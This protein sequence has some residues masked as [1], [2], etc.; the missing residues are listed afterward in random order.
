M[1]MDIL[2]AVSAGA[3]IAG[4]VLAVRWLSGGR[5][6]K[7]TIPAAIGA[8]IIAFSIWS[9]YSWFPR[10][11]AALPAEAP[12][13]LA[14][15]DPSPLR[16]WTY[17]F[18]LTT[19]FVAL[20]RTAMVTSAENPAIRRADAVVVQRW[21][22]TKRVPMG[23][24]CA[25]GRQVALTEGAVLAPDGTLTGAVWMTVAGDDKMQ[26]AACLGGA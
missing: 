14:P 12:I 23:F 11:S 18:P 21:N 4:I 1:L 10:V 22:S 24:D 9:E 7:W 3:G 19:R 20:D 13:V 16:P 5:M 25:A 8:G 2:A 17:V 6:P 26:M 15:A